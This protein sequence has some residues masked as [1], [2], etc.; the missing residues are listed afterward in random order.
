MKRWMPCEGWS[1]CGIERPA[2]SGSAQRRVFCGRRRRHGA[3]RCGLS[4]TGQGPSF[5]RLAE[6]AGGQTAD[7]GSIPLGQH[8]EEW[9]GWLEM[10]QLESVTCSVVV[11]SSRNGGRTAPPDVSTVAA[12][13]RAKP[14]T[15]RKS[16]S[17]RPSVGTDRAQG[18]AEPKPPLVVL[19]TPVARD[20]PFR[21]AFDRA[22]MVAPAVSLLL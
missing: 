16:R 20:T 1:K 9:L 15:S 11:A 6:V 21:A 14:G 17:A 12:F 2:R 22:G 13:D 5:L 10:A 19:R 8:L 4:L 7:P 3:R 18:I